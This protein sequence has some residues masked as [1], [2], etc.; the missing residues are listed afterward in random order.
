MTASAEAKYL[1][2][3][4]NAAESGLGLND[5]QKKLLVDRADDLNTLANSKIFQDIT[6]TMDN[7]KGASVEQL[8]AVLAIADQQEAQ[9]LVDAFKRVHDAIDT[10]LDERLG[11][12]VSETLRFKSALAKAASSRNISVEEKPLGPYGSEPSVLTTSLS[13]KIPNELEVDVGQLLGP[14]FVAYVQQEVDDGNLTQDV[15]DAILIVYSSRLISALGVEALAKQDMTEAEM[16]SVIE[17]IKATDEEVQ[18]AVWAMKTLQQLAD[19]QLETAEKPGITASEMMAMREAIYAF[20]TKSKSPDEQDALKSTETGG[21]D[22]EPSTQK[23][24]LS[25][26]E[27]AEKP[28]EAEKVNEN[29]LQALPMWAKTLIGVGIV[30]VLLALIFA[31]VAVTTPKMPPSRGTSYYPSQ[32]QIGQDERYIG[33]AGRPEAA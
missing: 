12:S 28:K 3:A 25:E 23:A 15:A 24:Q 17:K 6:K 10:V 27:K 13:T 11:L 31:V 16:T 21:D 33:Q 30:V 22:D 20:E 8:A 2:E 7:V 29:A 18:Q 4:L 26:P 9:K 32:Q 5:A 19:E 14:G 1:T